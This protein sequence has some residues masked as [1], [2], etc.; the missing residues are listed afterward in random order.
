MDR[1]KF[2]AAM[3]SAGYTQ[4]KLAKE[5]NM[6]PNTLSAKLRGKSRIC[7]DEVHLLC[8]LVGIKSLSKKAEIFLKD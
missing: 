8:G 3:L 1:E 2:R 6:S 4:A 7:I 5:A